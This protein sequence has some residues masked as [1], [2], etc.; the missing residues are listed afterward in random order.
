MAQLA[1]RVARVVRTNMDPE[2]I[3]AGALID[4]LSDSTGGNSLQRAISSLHEAVRLSARPAPVLA[5]LSGAYLLRAERTGATRDMFAAVEVAIQA[6]EHEPG[7]R[8]ALFNLG[9]GLQRLGLLEGATKVW[10]EYLVV[11]SRSPW[12]ARARQN[13]RGLRAEP[14]SAAPAAGAPE[15]AYA[16][17]AAADPQGGRLLGWC[18]IL[19]TWG[20]AVLA[21]DTV[22]A[23]A[24]FRRAELVAYALDRRTGGDRSLGDAI[25]S[26]RAANP[27]VRSRL[28][29]AHRD[30]AAGCELDNHVQSGA[31]AVRFAAAAWAADD[32]PAL[33]SWAR[34]LYG[35]ML[36]LSGDSRAGERIFREVATEANSA[37]QPALAGRARLLLAA[38]RLRRDRYDAVLEEAREAASLFS[39]AGEREQEGTALD[40]MSLAYFSTRDMD[41]GYAVAHRALFRL[42][43]YRS[44]YR[45]H[46][47]LSHLGQIVAD[48]GFPRAALRLKDEGVG[49]AEHTGEPT[50]IAEARLA[51]ARLL[52]AAGDSVRASEDVAAGFA[53]IEGISAPDARGWMVAQWQMARAATEMRARPLL[54]AEALDSAGATLLKRA[55][56]VALSP[57]VASAQA[58][59]AAGDA[60][61]GTVRL[62]Q[63]LA[64]LEA[65]R[66][67]VRMEPRRAAVFAAAGAVVARVALLKLA[68][69]RTTEALASVDRGRA[70]LASAGRAEWPRGDWAVTAPPGQTALEYA[71]V[72]DT[73]LIWTVTGRRVEVSRTTI[74][75]TGLARAIELLQRQL[76]RGAG[77]EELRPGLTRLFDLLVRPVEERLG[78]A[79]TPLVV[80]ADGDIAAIP[81][82]AL[83]DARR[84]RYLVEDHALRFSPSLRLAARRSGQRANGPA[85]FVADPAFR[86]STHAGFERLAGAAREVEEIAPGYPGAQV[87]SGAAATRQALLNGFARA[88]VVHVAAHAVFDNERPERS[89]LLLAG[90]PDRQASLEAGDIAQ[91]ELRHLALVVLSACRTVRTGNGRAEGLSG[92]GGAFLAAGAGGVVGSL[93]EVDDARTWPLMVEFHR[94]YRTRG[95]A[96]EALRAA[97]LRMLESGDAARRSPA[98]WA[99]FR[100]V[101]S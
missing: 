27:R 35:N 56:L 68:A 57:L 98:T 44:S 41:D 92:L 20:E 5:D 9:L 46:N 54:A 94:A 69:G 89:Y 87:I 38:L 1:A 32:S 43:P 101:G 74:D 97:Q 84:R 59:I 6:L 34:L 13:L 100:Y 16:V 11:D 73:L 64:M 80:V 63:A 75:S 47:L 83:F 86:P 15:Q 81:F 19:G 18:R 39:R 45:L 3:H 36:F 40:M 90:D 8:T 77:T 17:Y 72:G 76:E 49:I 61:G 53:A 7:N 71:L 28:A 33:A 65:R 23:A 4:L 70:S 50:F 22:R 67:S 30:F 93:W 14:P 37:R 82:A 31:A 24:A 52:A 2:A 48:D 12:A 88:R 42:Q 51:R 26:I 91:L 55:P 62:E 95:D 99:G 85:L 66:D 10:Q 96:P 58:R 21:N 79:G 78:G 60:A 29:R 25:R